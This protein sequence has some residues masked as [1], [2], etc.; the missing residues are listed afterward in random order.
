MNRE[1]EI[2]KASIPDD[3]MT[4]WIES[5]RLGGFSEQEVDDILANL[6]KTYARA[7]GVGLIEAELEKLENY[8][9]QKHGR[10]ITPEQR[11]HLRQSIAERPEFKEK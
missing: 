6:N 9:Q 7:K 8:L 10:K 11:E 5:L 4:G 1:S 2:Y 3:D